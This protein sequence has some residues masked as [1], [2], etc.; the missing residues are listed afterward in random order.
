MFAK[1]V[2]RGITL[3]P[4]SNETRGLRKGGLILSNMQCCH[5]NTVRARIKNGQGSLSNSNIIGNVE[6]VVQVM[7]MELIRVFW[8]LSQK[9]IVICTRNAS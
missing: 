2:A 7:C 8:S 4:R 9:F 3:N 6:V 1:H 5:L